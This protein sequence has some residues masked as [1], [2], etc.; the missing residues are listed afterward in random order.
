MTQ[1]RHHQR[2][3]AMNTDVDVIVVTDSTSPP[4]DAFINTKLLF[5]QQEARFSR[6][7]PD[8]LLCRL[9][10]GETIDEDRKSTRLNSSHSS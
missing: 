10:A 8:S 6:F 9:N 4:I 2:F 7:R 5:E 3:R 1:T